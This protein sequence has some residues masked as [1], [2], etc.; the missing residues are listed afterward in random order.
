MD[1]SPQKNSHSF[2][3]F[4]VS[5]EFGSFRFGKLLKWFCNHLALKSKMFLFENPILFEILDTLQVH[6]NSSYGK[7]TWCCFPT[8][9]RS[10][11]SSR[12]SPWKSLSYM[13]VT[14]WLP[15]ITHP[16]IHPSIRVQLTEPIPCRHHLRKVCWTRWG[17]WILERKRGEAKKLLI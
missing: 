3:D 10:R 16:S 1:G 2:Q 9:I 7:S 17:C 11:G 12:N 8:K 13:G 14:W 15:S 6:L 5:H 4:Q